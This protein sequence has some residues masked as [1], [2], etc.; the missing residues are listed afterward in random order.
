[1]N[2]FEDVVDEQKAEEDAKKLL[3]GQF[4]FDAFLE[5]IKT[6]Q[7]LGS[8]KDVMEKLPFFSDGLP[9]GA[10][11]DDKELVK[12]EAMIGSMTKQERRDPSVI[13]E[14]R[15]ARIA[16]G[17]GRTDQEVGDLLTRFNAMRDMM[18]QLG[19]SRACCP[20][21]RASSSSRR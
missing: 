3:S 13:N 1:M 19:D 12:I 15:I 6:I 10:N 20:A 8:L 4:D 21:S 17:S 2:D 16:K 5:Q 14:S 11:L 18:K 7:K 9:E